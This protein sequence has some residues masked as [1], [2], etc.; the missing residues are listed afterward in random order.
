MARLL[1]S[2]K[3]I[4][5][6]VSWGRWVLLEVRLDSETRNPKRYEGA[7]HRWPTLRYRSHF[8][9][10]KRVASGSGMSVLEREKSSKL[11][12]INC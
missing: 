1:I 2:A 12:S 10:T 3:E 5:E 4:N 8:L 7:V 11:K 6:F 9:S